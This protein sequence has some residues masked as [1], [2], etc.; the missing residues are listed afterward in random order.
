MLSW[1]REIQYVLV[2]HTAQSRSKKHQAT[3]GCFVQT[4][5]CVLS[6]EPTALLMFDFSLLWRHF[7]SFN[8]TVLSQDVVRTGEVHQVSFSRPPSYMTTKHQMNAQVHFVG[9][10]GR[11]GKMNESQCLKLFTS[12]IHARGGRRTPVPTW[13]KLSNSKMLHLLSQMHFPHILEVSQALFV[14]SI[15][16]VTL[17]ICSLDGGGENAQ[18]R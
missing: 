17:L 1:I 2:Q 4:A 13:A 8:N 7:L 9:R 6:G 18:D 5:G 14:Q 11:R 3:G 16:F 10:T 15:M 12:P